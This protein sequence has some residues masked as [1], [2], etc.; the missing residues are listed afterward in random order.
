MKR[1]WSALL[2]VLIFVLVFS[3]CAR[4]PA[5]PT[6][7]PTPSAP[8]EIHPLPPTP[9]TPPAPAA[10]S[11]PAK[12]TPPTGPTQPITQPSPT[13]SPDI[14]EARTALKSISN[15]LLTIYDQFGIDEDVADF[16]LFVSTLP[17]DFGNYALQNKLC[18]QDHKLTELEK[19]FLQEPAQYLQQMFDSYMSEIDKIDPGLATQLKKLPYFRAL[20]I[21]DVEA[22]EDFLWLASNS[23]YKSTLEKLYGKGIERKMHSIALE[24]LLWRAFTREYDTYNPLED[25][26]YS[27]IFARL[28]DFQEKYNQQMD[29]IEPVE[30]KK[31]QVMGIIYMCEPIG[32]L[33]K[34]DDDIRFDYALM[35]WVLGANAVK[36]WGVGPTSFDHVK[37]AHEEGLK[38]WLV[39]GLWTRLET[40]NPDISVE[41]YCKQLTG[42]AQAAEEA[43][44]EV[45]IVG[46][47]VD[48]H[49]KRFDYKT[50]AL[51]GAVDEM[52]KTAR[53][54][55]HGLV[56]YTTWD[57][58]YDICN[59]N[60]EPTDIIFPQIYKS[61]DARELTDSEYLSIIN[62]W[63]NKTPGKLMAISEFGSLTVSEGAAL[64][65]QSGLL[66]TKPYH[67]DT[68]AQADSIERNL[69]VLFKADVYG[70]FLHRWDDGGPGPVKDWEQVGYGIWDWRSNE[71]KPSFWVVYKYYRES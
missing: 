44:A 55:Y 54:N 53:Q 3:S 65:P 33:K 67:Y 26:N 4:A 2:A 38:V 61:K 66:K 29:E 51:R 9:T 18:I 22:V 21:K 25:P 30:G 41:D 11:Q 27:P 45:L 14:I 48:R 1:W 39:Y 56:T 7:A 5:S 57:G 36:I 52:V 35:K 64:G 6:T 24:A 43:K 31:P 42:F 12:P 19:K 70:I 50:G 8:T 47:E 68:Q 10:E 49:L 71:P 17:T 69:R 20:E 62:K 63:K 13:Q 60:W 15:S 46:D 40:T 28:A 34:T 32:W 59:I 58:P 23:K 16:V 37:F